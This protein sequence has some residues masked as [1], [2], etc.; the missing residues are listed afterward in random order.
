MRF[1]WSASLQCSV[2]EHQDLIVIV[3]AY[4]VLLKQTL[5]MKTSL[6]A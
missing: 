6:V 5:K 4:D 3:I 1:F 2:Q